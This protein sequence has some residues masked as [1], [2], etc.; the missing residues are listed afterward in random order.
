LKTLSLPEYVVILNGKDERKSKFGNGGKS[1]MKVLIRL[2]L[3][4]WK[5]L[6]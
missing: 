5:K 6:L 3:G 4:D 1:M 2:S